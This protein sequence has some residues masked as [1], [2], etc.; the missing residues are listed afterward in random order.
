MTR[1]VRSFRALSADPELGDRDDQAGKADQDHR[2]A[3]GVIVHISSPPLAAPLV[4]VGCRGGG[5]LGMAW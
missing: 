2:D 4:A 3:I 1:G 5:D